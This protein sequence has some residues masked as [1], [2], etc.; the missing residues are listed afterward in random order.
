MKGVKEKVEMSPQKE[1]RKGRP[2]M[3]RSLLKKEEKKKEVEVEEP[4]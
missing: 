3:A 2:I 1:K 4:E